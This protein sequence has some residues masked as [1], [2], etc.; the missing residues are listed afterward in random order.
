M[1]RNPA[2]YVGWPAVWRANPSHIMLSA[3]K[4]E[5]DR[6]QHDAPRRLSWLWRAALY[7]AGTP[8]GTRRIRYTRAEYRARRG[9]LYGVQRLHPART[10]QALWT[11][12]GRAARSLCHDARTRTQRSAQ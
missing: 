6:T 8:H 7:S 2:K 12:A 11:D 1:T 10:G 5:R 3:P 4:G 9:V